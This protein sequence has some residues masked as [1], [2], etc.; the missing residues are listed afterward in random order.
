MCFWGSAGA[1][2]ELELLVSVG[3]RAFFVAVEDFHGG[4]L[5]VG[6]GEDAHFS[7]SGQDAFDAPDVDF[8]AF[9]ARA[10]AGVDGE[11]EPG[12]AFFQEFFSEFVGYFLIFCGDGRQVEE[13][14]NPHK[15]IGAKTLKDGGDGV[16][17]RGELSE[18]WIYEVA[19][20]AGEAGG[21]RGCCSLVGDLQGF[22]LFFHADI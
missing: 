17:E 2:E 8:G 18:S 14:N 4:K 11:L 16:H 7:V 6:D 9:S 5:F 1:L 13:N 10:G 3:V 20:L 22:E 21:H 12:E 15:A 19:F